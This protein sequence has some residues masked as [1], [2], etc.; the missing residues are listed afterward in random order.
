MF[1]DDQRNFANEA[2]RGEL[3]I[4]A[5]GLKSTM[6]ATSSI[7]Q[8]L[9]SMNSDTLVALQA[10]QS[11]LAALEAGAGPGITADY[12]PKSIITQMVESERF[13]AK[14]AVIDYVK[15]NP[16][17]TEEDAA[18]AWDAAAIASHPDFPQVIQGA[19]VMSALYRANLLRARIITEDTW[20]A[21]RTF[22]INTAKSTIESM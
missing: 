7:A 1:T 13:A 5:A 19:L 18:Q 3:R 9:N 22:I 8:R 12:G 11:E 2:R 17:C 15:A 14:D 10:V 4:K 6:D 16:D 21:H 20:A